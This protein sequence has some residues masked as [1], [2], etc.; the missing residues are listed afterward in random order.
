MVTR[1]L[2]RLTSRQRHIH[3][4]RRQV[5][6]ARQ[7]T[8]AAVERAEQ[9][10]ADLDRAYEHISRLTLRLNAVDPDR[11]RGENADLRAEVAAL[12]GRREGP[13]REEY[14]RERATSAQVA[15]R[16]RETEERLQA[17]T[18]RLE[19][20]EAPHGQHGGHGGVTGRI[21]V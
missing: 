14:L 11:L 3:Q 20:L 12:R 16:L 5:D 2:K 18:E 13:S 17:A 4:L 1:L 10:R 19:A 21:S 8:H 9:L 7:E 6:A 15:E